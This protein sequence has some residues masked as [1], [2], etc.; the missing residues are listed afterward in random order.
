MGPPG[1]IPGDAPKVVRVV[2]GFPLT[3]RDHG[4]VPCRPHRNAPQLGST[5][6]LWRC[7]TVEHL[8][9]LMTN[10]RLYLRRLDAYGDEDPN[11]GTWLFGVE[12]G[13]GG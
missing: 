13:V 8:L 7:L 4:R 9:D 5:A 6:R 12:G 2:V 10:G 11:E 3:F 1:L